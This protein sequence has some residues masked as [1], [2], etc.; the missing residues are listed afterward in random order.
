MRKSRLTT[1]TVPSDL[2]NTRVKGPLWAVSGHHRVAKILSG[3]TLVTH[4]ND[5]IADP[6]AWERWRQF[7][8]EAY[9]RYLD[10]LRAIRLEHPGLTDYAASHRAG[11]TKGTMPWVWSA[12]GE[13]CET[14][15][16]MMLGVAPC[17]HGTLGIAWWPFTLTLTTA[18]RSSTTRS[19]RSPSFACFSL[20][21]SPT[22]SRW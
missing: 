1:D 18:G 8:I 7:S 19:S 6:G 21:T 10:E 4:S 17:I 9:T 11:A 3:R 20:A 15:N 13:L 2:G 16:S 14:I 12:A 5:S 22:G